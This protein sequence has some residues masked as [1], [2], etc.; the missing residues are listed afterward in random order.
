[1]RIIQGSVAIVA[2]AAAW[3]SLGAIRAPESV[4]WPQWRGP[5]QTGMSPGDAPLTWSD[6][7]NVRWKVEGPGRGFSS[8]IVAGDRIFLTTAVPTG[9]P[10]DQSEAQEAGGRGPGGGAGAGIEHRFELLA[11]NRATGKTLWQRTATVAT[12]HE[13][14]HRIYGSLASNSPATDGKRVYAFF[15]S[16]GLYA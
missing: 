10:A 1:M 6:S 14:Y 15:G 2:I 3:A 7:T 12:P 16:R 5:M 4:D 13:G 9:K 8:P 11:I